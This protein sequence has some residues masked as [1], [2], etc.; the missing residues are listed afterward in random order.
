MTKAA[1]EPANG[2]DTKIQQ[3]LGNGSG[4]HD[5]GGHYEQRHRQQDKTFIEPLQDLFTGQTNVLP[6]SR[7]I[8]N[9]GDKDGKT[10][11]RAD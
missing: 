7:Q 9:R 1:T 5:I 6:G 10:D 8:D 2:G 4:I 3:A 11:R